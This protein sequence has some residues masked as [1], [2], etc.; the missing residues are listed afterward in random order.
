MFAGNELA[1]G[2]VDD[3][4]MCVGLAVRHP[5]LCQ[6]TG[7]AQACR[8]RRS[9]FAP[10]CPASPVGAL[11]RGLQDAAAVLAQEVGEGS[12]IGGGERFQSL[13]PAGRQPN[14][15]LVGVVL[16]RHSVVLRPVTT[17]A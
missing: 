3:V 7:S 9:Q 2:F 4:G 11:V 8:S 15:H 12:F 10:L 5:G 17:R 14:A 13:A 6:R 16:L 1:Y